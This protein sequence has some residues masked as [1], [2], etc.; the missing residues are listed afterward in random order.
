[1]N[2]GKS[3]LLNALV[4]K[5]RALVS[6]AP[7]TTRDYLE[8]SDVWDGVAVTLIDTAGC[9]RDDAIRSSGAG[10]RSAR[11]GSRRRTWWSWSSTR[12]RTVVGAAAV[13]RARRAR[14]R[15]KADLAPAAV[16]DAAVIATTARTGEGLD[17]LRAKIL[18]V[19][20]VSERE[21]SEDAFVST[22]RQHAAAT[23]AREARLA[24]GGGRVGSTAAPGEIVALELREAS[25]ALAELR[26]VEVGE[27]VLDEVF[28]RFCIG[29]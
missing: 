14:V 6:A 3:S 27:R 20:G 16:A 21:G 5:E 13:R 25:R 28:A 1:M 15:S 11:R 2:A 18:A 29:K 22:A 26:G 17:A 9:A 12:R 8:V 24:G 7:G 10:P 23:A 4:G 19:A